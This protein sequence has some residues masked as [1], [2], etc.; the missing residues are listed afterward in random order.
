M[1]KDFTPRPYQS[2]IFETLANNNTLVVLPT[3]LGKTAI[4]MMIAARRL[5]LYPTK[6]IV[7]VAPTKPLVEQQLTSF[8]NQFFLGQE[9][10]A[11]FTGSIPPSQRKSLW[12]KARFIF[13][14]PQTIENDVLSG[15]VDLSEVS[16][17]IFDEAHRATGDYAY[18]FLAKKYVEDSSCVRIVALTASPGADVDKIKEVSSNLFIERIEYRSIDSPDVKPFT[19]NVDVKWDEVVLSKPHQRIVDYLT[20]AYNKK[21]KKIK[22]FGLL[23]GPVSSYS[24][25]QLLK[26]QQE[27]HSSISSGEMTPE[28]LQSISL[29]AES[30]KLSHAIELAQTQT[31]FALNEY[32]YGILS[33]SRNSKTKAIKNL[34]KDPDFLSALSITRDLLKENVEH[35]KLSILV[36][37]IKAI[38]DIKPDAKI[39][40]FS[41]YRDTASQIEKRLSDFASS[42]VFFG[43]AKKNGVSFSQKKQK[44]VLENFRENKFSVLIATSVAEEGLDIPSVD[45]VFFFEPVP[46]AIRSVQRRGRTGRHGE[47]FVN[48]LVTKGTKDEA[49]KWVSFH[50]E[51]RMY[52][53][54]ETLSKSFNLSSS[55]KSISSFERDAIKV[56][57]KNSTDDIKK[58]KT[59]FKIVADHREKGSALLKN[60][61][62]AGVDLQ[63]KQLDVGDYMLSPDVCVEFK[64]A[65]DFLDSIVDGR[66]LTQ[67]RS[68]VQYPKPLFV[69]EGDLNEAAS[70]KV[71]QNAIHG[72]LATIAISYRIPVLRTSGPLESAKLFITIAKREQVAGTDLFT[73]HTSKPL[74]EGMLQEYIVGSFPTIGPALAK[75]L[76]EHFDTIQK[77]ITASVDDFK[78]IPLIGDKKATELYKIFNQSYKETK[79]NPYK[80]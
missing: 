8:N 10:F 60:L 70:R 14:T 75:A 33:S 20:N 28:I 34:V 41:Q 22:E 57:Q 69:I 36:R 32:L 79:K 21:L 19:N 62:D 16:L 67:L 30:L 55:Q 25:T 63:L 47:G 24:K 71:D 13:S 35:P 51:K 2:A 37:R 26:M 18:V 6:K 3:G 40:V 29:L 7:F 78:K 52:S 64:N 17:F 74:E 61:I 72:M 49:S 56:M 77:I 48:V 59:D 27:L 66:I 12:K 31:L 38:L 80:Q 4:A 53:V 43:Q 1:L 50:K 45:F 46:S 23:Q 5:F 68:L 44:E 73:F 39:I 76:L 65:R 58:K 42:S 15:N 11:L 54:L 9:E